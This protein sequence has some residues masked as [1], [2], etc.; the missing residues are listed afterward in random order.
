MPISIG[1]EPKTL[2]DAIAHFQEDAPTCLNCGH[3]AARNGACYKCLNCPESLGVVKSSPDYGS[4]TFI[5]TN[6]AC[7]DTGKRTET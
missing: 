3:V 4:T 2:S 5:R 7:A 6:W 1:A